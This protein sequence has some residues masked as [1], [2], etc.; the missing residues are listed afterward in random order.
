M[1]PVERPRRV[2][3]RGLALVLSTVVLGLLVTAWTPGLG[4]AYPF[5]PAAGVSVALVL[6]EGPVLLPAVALGSLLIN[7]MLQSSAPWFAL[8]LA[9]GA[10][11][12]TAVAAHLGRRI[13]GATPRLRTS[14]EI[15]GF[16]LVT[17]PLSCVIGALVSAIA[18]QAFGIL[19]PAELPQAGFTWW[20][21]DVLG[22]VVVTPITLMLLPEMHEAW[23]G[24]R[25][26]LL[27]PSVL[28][29]LAVE[30][31][32]GQAVALNN[33]GIRADL[34]ALAMDAR[35][36]LVNNLDRHAEAIDSVRR[37]FLASE[38]VS[39]DEF[40]AFTDD[41]LKRLP[42]L[43]GLSYNPLITAGQRQEFEQQ[44]AN[45]PLLNGYRITER[46]AK[47]ELVDAGV[48]PRY[49][50]VGYIEPLATNQAALGYDIFSNPSRAA[51]IRRA[52]RSGSLQATDPITLVQEQG[53]QHGV[54]V[55]DPIKQKDGRL[56]GFAVGVYRLGDL[57][58]SSFA[59]ADAQRWQ[60][61]GFELRSRGR[62]GPEGLL[63]AHGPTSHPAKG[64]GVDVPVSFAGQHW[65]LS[66][67]P[68]QAALI[69]RQST[70]PQQLLLACLLL[71][72]LNQAFLLVVTGKEQ[73]EQREARISHY[74]ANRDPLT[75]LLNR[76][77]FMAALE[78]ARSEADRGAVP[79]A[80]LVFDL[81]HFKPINDTAGHEAGDHALKQLSQCVS[82]V[83]RR[84]DVLARL[85]GDEFA[86]ILRNCT[87]GDAPRIAAKLLAAI[88]NL[89]ISFGG[90]RFVVTASLG[91][92]CLDRRAG[93]LPLSR[94]LLRDADQA[95]YKAKSLGRN[96]WVVVADPQSSP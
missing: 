46:N 54:L 17:G 60:G 84:D 16:L 13:A 10:T 14:R 53:H 32:Y 87:P 44:Q 73:L 89:E 43:Q 91:I 19:T 48:R 77:A 61:I 50:P 45:D 79:H 82:S 93:P 80:L 31:A 47:G 28:L 40:H 9:C 72:I 24:R 85:G 76:R 4:H 56:S 78:Q 64:W 49:V 62:P 21:G 23:D 5:W 41:L 83:L 12:Q 27:L 37:L 74:L 8:V 65:T 68:S 63:A 96:Q 39:A 3:W 66:L 1:L 57:L 75:D 7:L 58:N 22:V 42:G 94:D 51:A 36:G 35:H 59:K 86:V 29:L 69:Q 71:I 30:L 70:L 26:K 2:L 67:L 55:L 81:D 15:L 38:F 11:L 95:C 18:S 92:R 20:A 6:A 33:Q 88:Q 25:I 34:R 90:Q 52:E